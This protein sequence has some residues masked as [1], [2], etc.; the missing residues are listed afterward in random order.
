MQRIA[1]CDYLR[2]IGL[3]EV[4][5]TARTATRELLA[6]LTSAHSRAI[7]FENLDVVLG[8][9]I[10]MSVLAVERK[11]V[12]AKRRGGYCFEQNVLLAAALSMLGFVTEPLL[13]RVRWLKPEG[14]VT[15][16]THLAYRVT[17]EDG[18]V[19]L[20]D[21]GFAGTNS[22]APLEFGVEERLPEGLF[23][24]TEDAASVPRGYTALQ[25]QLR[26]V[27]RDLYVFRTHEVACDAD[28]H[29]SNYFSCSSPEARFTR[30]FFVQRVIGDERHYILDDL[31][32]IRRGHGGE[33][34]VVE[35]AVRDEARLGNLLAGV[36]G[37]DAPDGIGAAW[38]ERYAR[39]E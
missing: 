34:E 29:M 1:L 21:V 33:S 14:I 10:D 32:C 38:R 4:A 28:L 17:A 9:S 30:Q 5:T 36:F 12:G 31:Y 18:K 16:F 20:V 7:P 26:G 37:I 13:C 39:R 27:W 11:L 25:W 8:S 22:I 2:R 6:I 23:R 24:T 15:P 19:Y 35:E 3:D